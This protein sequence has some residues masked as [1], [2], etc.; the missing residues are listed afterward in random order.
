MVPYTHTHNALHWLCNH[1]QPLTCT[2]S[3]P[4][5]SLTPTPVHFPHISVCHY[6]TPP[7]PLPLLHSINTSASPS[8]NERQV[9]SRVG[10]TAGLIW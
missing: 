1:V 9:W 4:S 8:N 6:I 7:P 10:E 2:H 5:P 3:C